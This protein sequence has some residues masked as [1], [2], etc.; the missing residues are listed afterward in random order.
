VIRYC[1]FTLTQD[2]TRVYARVK[3]IYQL[4]IEKM[5]DENSEL[6]D[7]DYSL[8][9]S[10]NQGQQQQ[11]EPTMTDTIQNEHELENVESSSGQNAG[12]AIDDYIENNH[13]VKA[14]EASVAPSLTNSEIV[15]S[16]NISPPKVAP[17]LD[18]PILDDSMI[19][20]S[21][22]TVMFS[23]RIDTERDHVPIRIT[24]SHRMKNPLMSADQLGMDGSLSPTSQLKVNYGPVWK[25]GFKNRRVESDY[26]KNSFPAGFQLKVAKER[27]LG[28]SR[29]GVLTTE[30]PQQVILS[31]S[32]KFSFT[33]WAKGGSGIFNDDSIDDTEGPDGD[34]YADYAG[35]TLRDLQRARF[36]L[37]PLTTSIVGSPDPAC[38]VK[39]MKLFTLDDIHK[40]PKK[41]N[42]SQVRLSSLYS[43]L[44]FFNS[45]HINS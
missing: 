42:E 41:Q 23:D 31:S 29:F 14:E 3:Y 19:S 1:D 25:P 26:L 9:S 39:R 7:D 22:S 20:G 21:K 17:K 18:T 24:S 16:I 36:Q 37:Q 38:Q 30:F 33:G 8:N 4:E 43:S 12:E 15:A 34:P 40:K 6:N 10:I 32:N 27:I 45:N 5:N 2:Y 35:P 28:E 44:S 11:Q 13:D